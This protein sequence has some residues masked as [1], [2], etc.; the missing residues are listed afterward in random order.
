MNPTEREF[1]DKLNELDE[2]P[3]I[4]LARIACATSGFIIG[5]IFGGFIMWVLL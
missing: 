3:S 1:Y 5:L 2:K 4:M